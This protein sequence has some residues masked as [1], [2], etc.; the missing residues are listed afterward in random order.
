MDIL[1]IFFLFIF[2]FIF[3]SVPFG[4]IL[5][6]IIK[7]ID[8]RK[9]GSGNIGAT[10]VYRVCGGF[11]GF[12]VLFLDIIKGYI[13]VFI[14]RN[15]LKFP[16]LIL[17]FVGLAAILGH[18][19]SIFLKG[20]GG[21][22]IS[23][24]FGVIIALFPKSA[25][26]SFVIFLVVF[27]ISNIVSISSITASFFLPIFI[28]IFYDKNIPLTIFGIIIF[29]FIIYTHKENIKRLKKREEK[30]IILPWKKK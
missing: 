14:S 11:L 25:F 19:F 21:K 23:T 10:N 22:G 5:C 2:S 30:K 16:P 8:I 17:I 13:P 9:Y 1:K 18:T 27:L 28:Y 29:I 4:Y 7:K 3:G 20:K 12:S 15:F 26:F 6:K 24:S